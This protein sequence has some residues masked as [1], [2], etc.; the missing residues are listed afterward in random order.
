MK[1]LPP[2]GWRPAVAD[3][4]LRRLTLGTTIALFLLLISGSYVFGSGTSLACNG[5]PFC[6][7][8]VIPGRL[9]DW[10]N[11]S[12]R[13]VAAVVGVVVLWACWRAWQARASSPALGWTALATVVLFALQV[14]A[15]AYV[16]FERLN[17]PWPALHLAFAAAV[18]GAFVM[19]TAFA[20]LPRPEEAAA[21]ATAQT[22]LRPTA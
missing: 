19:L 10:V 18:W 8:G 13:L 14:I 7:S 4:G 20:G 12:H 16:V 11:F 22:R 6:E 5:W 21:P 1:L 17:G 3:P 9:S 15:G 2:S